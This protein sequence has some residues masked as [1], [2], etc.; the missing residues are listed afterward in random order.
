M[1]IQYNFNYLLEYMTNPLKIG[2]APWEAP[3]QINSTKGGGNRNTEKFSAAIDSESKK[4]RSTI[5]QI[6][7]SPDPEL[8]FKALLERSFRLRSEP[9]IKWNVLTEIQNR[10]FKIIA[11]EYLWA[12][13]WFKE[14]IFE[15]MQIIREYKLNYVYLEVLIAKII[16]WFDYQHCD[17]ILS[18]N[19]CAEDFENDWLIKL[20]QDQNIPPDRLSLEIVESSLLKDDPIV[21]NNLKELHKLGYGIT[22]DD[23]NPY[24]TKRDGNFSS[25]NLKILNGLNILPRLLKLDGDFVKILLE[26]HRNSINSNPD[27]DQLTRYM[28]HQIMLKH[29]QKNGVII[30]AEFVDS[31]ADLEILMTMW[32]TAGQGWWLRDEFNKSLNN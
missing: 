2:I 10:I 18:W 6:I 28:R 30:V 15:M 23:F 29:R 32:I 3:V 22:I 31:Q 11:H 25:E 24:K 21:K 20:I 5:E 19:L 12:I 8:E 14:N 9:M 26:L 27:P 1:G 7:K 17:H 13:D 16:E 4:F